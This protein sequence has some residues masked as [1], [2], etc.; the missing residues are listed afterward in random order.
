MASPDPAKLLGFRI[1]QGIASAAVAPKI[2]DKNGPPA[3]TGERA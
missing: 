3:S 1:S 2:G